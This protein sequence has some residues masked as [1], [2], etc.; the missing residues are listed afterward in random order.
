M[1]NC[2]TTSIRPTACIVFLP[3][4]LFILKWFSG[5]IKTELQPS[6]FMEMYSYGVYLIDSLQVRCS[7]FFNGY[8]I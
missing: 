8:I 2:A 3:M 7:T 6:E 4:S 5:K 1:Y